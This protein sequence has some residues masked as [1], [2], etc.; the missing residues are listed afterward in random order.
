MWAAQLLA[1]EEDAKQQQ[2]SNFCLVLHQTRRTRVLLHSST[3]RQDLKPPG[4]TTACRTNCSQR[5]KNLWKLRLAYR[6]QLQCV[7]VRVIRG[8]ST[9]LN[10]VIASLN[11]THFR[12]RRLRLTG[13]IVF[14]SVEYSCQCEHTVCWGSVRAAG[15]GVIWV[16][17]SNESHHRGRRTAL[18]SYARRCNLI[19][20]HFPPLIRVL[21]QK[22]VYFPGERR[23]RDYLRPEK[24]PWLLIMSPDH[25]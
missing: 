18:A 13:T 20:I 15:G 25:S 6:F 17:L 10:L 22:A 7:P 9:R 16:H 2:Q 8:G 11:V 23:R 21:F 4:T 12:S 14:A 24:T 5:Q 3:A 1:G 19:L